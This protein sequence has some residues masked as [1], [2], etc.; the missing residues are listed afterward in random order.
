MT[1]DIGPCPKISNDD[2]VGLWVESDVTLDCQ[3][4]SITGPGDQQQD[5]FGV[6]VGA[7]L[8][9]APAQNVTV[10]NCRVSKFWW[11][12]YVQNAH[13]VVIT[14]NEMDENGWK[15]LTANG[16]G[17][18]LDVANS[19]H[20]TVSDN[21]ITDSGNEGFHLSHSTDVTVEG[22]VLSDNGK[23]Q[24]YLF[25]ADGNTVRGNRATGGA[26]GLEMRYSSDNFFS[27][28]VWAGSKKQWL[29]NDNQ[30]NLFFYDHF[31]GLVR[32]DNESIG[33]R[34]ELCAFEHTTDACL[35]IT[36]IGTEVYKGYFS[37]DAD[38]Q[39]EKKRVTV[40]SKKPVTLDRCAGVN[41]VKQAKR[42]TLISPGCTADLDTDGDVDEADRTV[43]LAALPSTIGEQSWNPEGD[44]NHDGEVNNDDVSLFDDQVGPCPEE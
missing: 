39:K 32:V 21:A 42:A 12:I 3:G 4:H 22:N 43:L 7:K 38:Q 17:Y 29:E 10:Q 30:Q 33:N 24:L 8:A 44:L 27:Y 23:E 9:P 35:K 5:E 15:D 19:H 36:A 41:K 11:G 6:R 31:Q 40:R 16:T 1:Y 18:G 14:R 2:T 20:I 13:D 34:F 28:N 37:C 26:Q 25:F